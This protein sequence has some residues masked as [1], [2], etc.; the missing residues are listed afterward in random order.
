MLLIGL[1]KDAV[2]PRLRGGKK[3]MDKLAVVMLDCRLHL[4]EDILQLLQVVR[5][6]LAI[7]HADIRPHIGVR[8][9]DA[10]RIFEAAAHELDARF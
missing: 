9:S 5:D 8:R 1:F 7:R 10:R 2:T 3:I 4:G 6:G